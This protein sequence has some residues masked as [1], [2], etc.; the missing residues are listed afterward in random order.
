MSWINMILEEIKSIKSTKKELREFGIV[1]GIAFGLIGGVLFWQ[2]KSN[3]L[4]F[5]SISLFL[6][7]SGLVF[8]VILKPLQKVWMTLAIV[9][10]FFMTKV[11]LGLLYYSIVSLIAVSFKIFKKDI[12]NLKLN[13]EADSYWIQREDSDFKKEN[14]ERQ[15]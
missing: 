5:F 8:P 14:C 12:L 3:Y 10:G 6:L 15:F 2:Y 4:I 13:R 9:I 1:V 7:I 11:I